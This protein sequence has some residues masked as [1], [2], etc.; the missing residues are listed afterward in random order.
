MEQK[1]ADDAGSKQ[2]TV[3]QWVFRILKMQLNYFW[4]P[5]HSTFLFWAHFTVQ[6]SDAV[7]LD[8]GII[9]FQKTDCFVN[10]FL[11]W[12]KVKSKLTDKMSRIIS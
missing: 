8:V 3:A 12:I 10:I 9:L 6:R 11:N 7:V 2:T 5:T 4:T 1:Q